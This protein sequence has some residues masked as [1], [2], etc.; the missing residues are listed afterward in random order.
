[1]TLLVRQLQPTAEGLPLEIYCFTS[2]WAGLL[3]AAQSTS[4]TTCWRFLPE[5][6]LRVFQKMAIRRST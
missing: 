1:M 3:Q 2:A 5:F 4:S 6:G